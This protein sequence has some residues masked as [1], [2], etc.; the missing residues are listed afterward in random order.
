MRK[1]FVQNARLRIFQ[2]S[3]KV[4]AEKDRAVSK[5]VDKTSRQT[6]TFKFDR[7]SNQAKMNRKVTVK[8]RGDMNN[9]YWRQWQLLKHNTGKDFSGKI[10]RHQ[11]SH[12]EKKD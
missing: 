1:L 12:N 10:R 6:F 11:E 5:D 2:K 7:Q 8:N 3:R 4:W 9:D